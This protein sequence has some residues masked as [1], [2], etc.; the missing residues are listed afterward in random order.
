[1]SIG[2]LFLD[3]TPIWAISRVRIL[4]EH[5]GF[6]RNQIFLVE[7]LLPRMK[8]QA[9]FKQ[10]SRKFCFALRIMLASFRGEGFLTEVDFQL[11]NE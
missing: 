5:I 9:I 10:N 8:Y 4:F 6:L 2:Q 1:M 3:I 7:L 11:S